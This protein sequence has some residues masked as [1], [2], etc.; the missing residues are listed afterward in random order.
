MK[1]NLIALLV[2]IITVISLLPIPVRS[3]TILPDEVFLEQENTSSCTLS[4]SAMMLRGKLL[5][6]GCSRWQEVTESAIKPYAWVSQGLLWNWSYTVDGITVTVTHETLNGISMEDLKAIVDA[7]PEGIVLHVKSIPHSVLLTDYEGDVFYCADPSSWYNGKRLRM[8]ES[9]LGSKV[10]SQEAILRQVSAYWYVASCTT[11]N[12][13][14]VEESRIYTITYDANG[15]EHA[16]SPTY[17]Y[18]GEGGTLHIQTPEC[19]GFAFLGWSRDPAATAPSYYPNGEID[20][21]SDLTLY[22]VWQKNPYSSDTRPFLDILQDDYYYDP[23]LWAVNLG[24]TSGTNPVRFSPNEPCTRAQAV[25]FL[26]RSAGMPSESTGS[27]PFA[28]VPDNAYYTDAVAWAVA[29][30]ITEGTSDTTFSPDAPCTRGQIVTFLRRFLG[31]TADVSGNPFTDI[32]KGEYYYDAVLW[33]VEQGITNGMA[34]STFAPDNICTRGQ[35]VTFLYRA[36]N[37]M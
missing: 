34:A 20:T 6:S 10:G 30:G 36:M 32:S 29:E 18:S 3:A 8:D 9:Y 17:A 7:H 37:R 23:V 1:K 5:L 12:G 11:S 14:P 24:I 27:T 33:A 2:C 25:T 28:D 26:Y 22:A 31:G 19:S 15:G 13:K 21:D 4:T 35:I 16:P